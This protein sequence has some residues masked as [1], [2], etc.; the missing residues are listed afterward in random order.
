[1]PIPFQ[2]LQD[3]ISRAF[4]EAVFDLVDTH[5]DFDHYQLSIYDPILAAVAKVKS[6]RII[7]KAIEDAVGELPHA[8]SI[9]VNQSM[10][11]VQNG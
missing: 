7:Y 6:H 1:M 4:P 5:G 9:T 10:E 8:L 2:T 11:E 3:I